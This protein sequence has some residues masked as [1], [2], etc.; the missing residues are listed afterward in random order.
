MKSIDASRRDARRART[1]LPLSGNA[2]QG[3][4]IVDDISVCPSP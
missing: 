2:R 3:A 4:I 1:A